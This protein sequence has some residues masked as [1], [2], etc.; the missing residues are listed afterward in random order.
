[1]ITD[2]VSIDVITGFLGSG[3]TTLLRHILEHGLDG[4]RVAVVMNELGD[5]GI[6]GRVIEGMN[7]EKMI[8]LGSGCVCCTINRAFGL[9]LQELVETVRPE[10]VIV[11]TTGVAEPAN[12]VLETRQVGFSVDATITVVDAANIGFQLTHATAA[13]E[14]IAGADFVVLNKIDLV[15]EA[16]ASEAEAAI[17]AINPRALVVRATR[18]VVPAD[19]VFGTAARTRLERPRDDGEGA[20]SGHL[21]RDRIASFVYESDR[22]FDRDRFEHFLEGLPRSIYRAKGL[23]RFT[24]SEWSSLFNFTCGRADFEWRDRVGAGFRGRCVFIGA[25]AGDLR[26]EISAQLEACLAP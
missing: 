7:V 20:P 9:A 17:R 25:G 22:P 2:E 12:I 1:M 15:D 18:G 5:V 3:K 14:Q 16:G 24:E 11:E 8:E 21:G 4:R 23:V 13:R 10:L 26:G 6:D 19:V